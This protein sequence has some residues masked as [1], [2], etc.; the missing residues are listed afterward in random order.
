MSLVLKRALSMVDNAE[1]A[2]NLSISP[3]ALLL[4]FLAAVPALMFFATI[5]LIL[6]L[7]ARNF[8][9]ANAFAT[10]VMLIPLASL[11]VGIIE[12]APTPGILITPVAN[13]TVIIREVLV[14][15]ATAGAFAMAFA[16]S[17]VYAGLM[18]SV[19]ARLFSN[20]QLVNPAWEPLSVKGFR[21]AG[22][23]KRP[24]RLPAVDEAIGLFVVSLLLLF[25][26]TPSFIKAGLIPIVLVNQLLLVLAPALLWAWAARWR[27][28]ETF[29]WR[30]I[31]ATALV[32][33]ALIGVGLVPWVQLLAILQNHVWHQ[34]PD[35][36]AKLQVKLIADA[37][38][39][40]PLLTILL[41]GGLAGFCEEMLFRGPL[42]RALSRKLKPWTAITITAF[43]FGAAHMDLHGLP[44]RTLLGVLLGYVVWRGGSIFPGMLLHALY[45]SAALTYFWWKLRQEGASAVAA[46]GDVTVVDT[47][48]GILLF[49]GAILIGAGIW[50]FRLRLPRRETAPQGFPAVPAS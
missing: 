41:V 44:A 2:R 26:V 23:G 20:E 21:R 14:G 12:P 15:R 4:T 6:G 39:A 46:T 29:S 3:I 10:P 5:V 17:L 25:Y 32:G 16:S 40:H 47:E 36:G 28:A 1:L 50:M 45:D 11:A 31:A 43:L 49:I 48:M 7:L 34:M 35:E 19:A 18:L 13:T 22:S 9:E 30:R 38:Q 33:A 37:L 8:R 27:W 42:Q 24:R